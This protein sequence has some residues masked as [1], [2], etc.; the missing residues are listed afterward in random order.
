MSENDAFDYDQIRKFYYLGESCPLEPSPFVNKY[1]KVC[2]DI[3]YESLQCLLQKKL[4]VLMGYYASDIYLEINEGR[5]LFKNRQNAVDVL[6]GNMLLFELTYD[7]LRFDKCRD[8]DHFFAI[9]G[10]YMYQLVGVPS[11]ELMNFIQNFNAKISDPDV[12]EEITLIQNTTAAIYFE[13]FHEFVHLRNDLKEATLNLFRGTPAFAEYAGSLTDQQLEEAACDFNALYMMT[14]P[15]LPISKTL[16]ENF[17]CTATD[18]LAYGII[19]QH[20]NPLLQVLKCCFRLSPSFGSTTIEDIFRDVIY[21]LNTRCK[22]LLIAAKI[23]ENTESISLGRL[24]INKAFNHASDLINSFFR[25]ASDA[26]TQMSEEIREIKNT[27]FSDV[28]LTLREP[29][30]R[31]KIWFLIK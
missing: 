21:Q 30:D 11:K 22:I 29:I 3:V 26:L 23:S 19:M 9:F 15:I 28:T 13:V 1:G 2:F 12:N 16:E 5:S 20:A 7:L 31:E 18:M 24:D 25:C 10:K 4:P 17:K 14:N 8:T 6:W 27:Y